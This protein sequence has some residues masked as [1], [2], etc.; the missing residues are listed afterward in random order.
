VI[1]AGVSAANGWG[2]EA[3]RMLS[4]RVFQD[5][6]IDPFWAKTGKEA[7]TGWGE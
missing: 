2:N 5:N 3:L 4:S 1:L 6:R 7:R